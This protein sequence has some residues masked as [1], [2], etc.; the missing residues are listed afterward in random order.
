MSRMAILRSACRP[1]SA[2]MV[3]FS[4]TLKVS[5]S[6]LSLATHASR[7]SPYSLMDAGRHPSGGM[8]VTPIR[9][10]PSL[11]NSCKAE[12]YNAKCE[13]IY[14]WPNR[15]AEQRRCTDAGEVGED[16]D[17]EVGVLA[18]VVAAGQGG[19]VVVVLEEVAGARADDVQRVGED[20]A[21]LGAPGHRGQL[22]LVLLV[23][24]ELLGQRDRVLHVC[25]TTWS[26]GP[27]VLTYMAAVSSW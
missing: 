4:F 7:P 1:F 3:A 26:T 6:R 21:R 11:Y 17:E 18:D 22:G 15:N 12:Q 24:L 10:A 27:V 5:A 25:T 13:Y 9:R 19:V 16:A 23:V 14:G 2:L 8:D 20:G